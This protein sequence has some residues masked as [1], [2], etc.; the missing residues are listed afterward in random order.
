MFQC[1]ADRSSSQPYS[2]A[3]SIL[4]T[5][6]V[7]KKF[8]YRVVLGLAILLLL[9]FILPIFIKSLRYD[10]INNGGY[11]P[12]AS[13][14]KEESIE[15]GVYICDLELA[16][17]H[18][19][20]DSMKFKIKEAWIERT[21]Y[22]AAWYWTTIP[23]STG[24]SLRIHTYLN[25]KEEERLHIIN[26]RKSSLG[27][28]EGLG[29]SDGTCYGSIQQMPKSDTIR[30]NLLKKDNIDFSDKNIVGEISFIVKPHADQP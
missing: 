5:I 15:R 14:S 18:K 30:F 29:C 2:D 16:S 1:L 27:N 28:F 22:R 10:F 13:A 6:V 4:N 9:A 21:W 8:I 19:Q 7:M 17:F 25:E 11:G 12:S 20:D 26:N 23:D 24:L 3:R